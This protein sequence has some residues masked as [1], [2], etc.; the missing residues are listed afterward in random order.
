MAPWASSVCPPVADEALDWS[1]E[2]SFPLSPAGNTY[3][4]TWD[5]RSVVNFGRT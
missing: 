4:Q 1:G 2:T 3:Y 5:L